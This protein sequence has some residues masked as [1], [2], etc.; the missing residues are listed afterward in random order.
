MNKGGESGSPTVF[1]NISTYTL[2]PR[3]AILSY[4]QICTIDAGN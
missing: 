1:P 2:S 4:A 3:E